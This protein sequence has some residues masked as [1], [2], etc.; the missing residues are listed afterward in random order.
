MREPL[1]FRNPFAK[2]GMPSCG[3]ALV[4]ETRNSAITLARFRSDDPNFRALKSL[5]REDAFVLIFQRDDV[6]GHD[7]WANGRHGRHEHHASAPGSALN[8]FDIN[9]GP[10]CWV[11]GRFDNIHLH[12]PRTALDDLADD[13]NAPVVSALRAPAGWSTTDP[14]IAGMQAHLVAAIEQPSDSSQMFVDHVVL[15]LHAHIA[16]TFGGMRETG[17]RPT[18]G[19]APWQVRRAKDLV[20]ANL[21]REMSLQQIATECG[22]SVAHF[23]RAFKMSTGMTPHDWLQTCRVDHARGLLRDADLPLA[24]IANLCGF[25]DQ[26]HFTRIF[27]RLAGTAPGSW[28]RQRRQA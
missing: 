12:I 19:L 6:P 11:S 16:R 3:P 18:G 5:P 15:A 9:A 4:T 1:P 14:V 20:A 25:A 26:S 8:I 17:R 28:R 22:L 13:A 2:I 10:T 27:A 24:Q 21:S 7:F 23:S